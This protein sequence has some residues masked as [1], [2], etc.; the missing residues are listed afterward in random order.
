MIQRNIS[1][2]QNP[3]DILMFMLRCIHQRFSFNQN[4]GYVNPKNSY[5]C[6]QKRYV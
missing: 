1:G 2:S 3:T 4:I 6:Y 5:F